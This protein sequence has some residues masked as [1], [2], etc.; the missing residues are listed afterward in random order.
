MSE[1]ASSYVAVF[2]SSVY[3]TSL[4]FIF[5]QKSMLL[6]YN[7]D[8][9]YVHIVLLFPIYILGKEPLAKLDNGISAGIAAALQRR[10][11]KVLHVQ[12]FVIHVQVTKN[13]GRAL[14]TLCLF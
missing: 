13:N 2:V 9:G 7:S 10:I 14:S 11:S 1:K 8:M 4:D 6:Q 5:E 12:R 3:S